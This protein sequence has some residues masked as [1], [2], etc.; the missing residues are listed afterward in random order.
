MKPGEKAECSDATWACDPRMAA[1]DLRM[2]CAGLCLVRDF[3]DDVRHRP[4]RRPRLHDLARAWG[5]CLEVSEVRSQ[6]QPSW[7]QA[8][9]ARGS[10]AWTV[11][12]A[13]CC[14]MVIMR[15]SA[16][17]HHWSDLQTK[18]SSSKR[19]CQDRD[20]DQA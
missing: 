20:E 5:G 17:M 3:D 7:M 10:G 18:P 8:V 15:N 11:K 6:T 13:E 4:K 1:N 9:F 14:E 2:T 19:V 12:T 16:P